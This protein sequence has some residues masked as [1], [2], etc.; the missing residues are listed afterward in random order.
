ML[1]LVALEDWEQAEMFLIGRMCTSQDIKVSLKEPQVGSS[2]DQQQNA[3]MIYK[4]DL[5]QVQYETVRH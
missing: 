2:P 4:A 5:I 1:S 3:D